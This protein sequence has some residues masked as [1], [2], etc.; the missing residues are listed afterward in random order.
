MSSFS[1]KLL[2]TVCAT[3][4]LS[5]A[6]AFS[7]P[8]HSGFVDPYNCNGGADLIGYGINFSLDK[9]LDPH[10]DAIIGPKRF[11]EWRFVG[12]EPLSEL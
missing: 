2:S 11:Q 7:D 1:S 9:M 6:N 10:G 3:I 4:A 5:C 12:L 8:R